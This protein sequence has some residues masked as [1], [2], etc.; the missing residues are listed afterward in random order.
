MVRKRQVDNQP[1]LGFGSIV[2]SHSTI[3]QHRKGVVPFLA[4]SAVLALPDRIE[5]AAL[6][7]GNYSD[8]GQPAYH[9]S[10]SAAV[11]NSNGVRNLTD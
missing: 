3:A 2:K 1:L 7:L 6:Y 8:A 5:K 4:V 9:A 10:H 11:V